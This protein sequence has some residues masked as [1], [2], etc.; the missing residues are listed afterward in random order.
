MDV[1]FHLQS[2]IEDSML[3]GDA[4]SGVSVDLAKAY[5]LVSRPVLALVTDHLGWPA[6]L[7]RSYSTF[8]SSLQRF[9]SVDKSLYGPCR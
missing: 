5:N 6:S 9:F 1:A 7:Q 4:I 3:S 8:L 2:L